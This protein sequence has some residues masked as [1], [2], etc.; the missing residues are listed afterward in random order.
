MTRFEYDHC[1][2]L[3]ENLDSVLAA[4]GAEG[5]EAWAIE[6]T[7]RQTDAQPVFGHHVYFKRVKE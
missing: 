2:V 1:H 3:T 7:V 6:G 5:W 4:R